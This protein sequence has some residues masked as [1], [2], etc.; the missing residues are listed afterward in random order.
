MKIDWKKK[1]AS[2]KFWLAVAAFAVAVVALFAGSPELAD[3]I[4]ALILAA[5]SVI[6]YIIG[7]SITDAAAAKP[8][9]E[10]KD[11][12][13]ITAENEKKVLGFYFSFN[14]LISVKKKF[15]IE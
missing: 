2:R 11:D 12:K 10:K 9:E 13:L 14:P 6:A 5:G 8:V 3:R 7:E 4:S 15:N 1:L